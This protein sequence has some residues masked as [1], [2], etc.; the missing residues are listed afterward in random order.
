MDMMG[1]ALVEEWRKHNPMKHLSET[2][3]MKRWKS[4]Y[5]TSTNQK[6]ARMPLLMS[7]K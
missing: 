1:D 7:N 4:V 6:E 3:K 2:L 5:H